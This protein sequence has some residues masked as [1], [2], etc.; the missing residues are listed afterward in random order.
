MLVP[1]TMGFLKR[2]NIS[3]IEENKLCGLTKV[4][5]SDNS[6]GLYLKTFSLK[7]GLNSLRECDEA[8]KVS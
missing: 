6:F 1:T 3:L 4:Y 8:V 2:L 5:D 7:V